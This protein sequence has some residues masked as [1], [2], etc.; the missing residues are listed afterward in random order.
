MLGRVVHRLFQAEVRGDLPPDELAAIARGMVAGDEAWT[1]KDPGRLAA[2][3]A[4]VFSTMWSQPALRE[5][6]AG[7]ECL[8]EVPISVVPATGTE[9]ESPRI[10]RGVVD[11]LACR[12]DGRVVV[13]DFKTGARRAADR[14]QLG[15]YVEAVRSLYPGAPIEGLLVYGPPES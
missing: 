11:C 15:A 8:Y 7:A 9:G 13:V 14:R 3:A 6:L 5:A 10:M 4:R 1:T 12:P 2:S